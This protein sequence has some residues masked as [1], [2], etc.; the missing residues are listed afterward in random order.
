MGI[1]EEVLEGMLSV[2]EKISNVQFQQK[3]WVENKV[4]QYAFF[5]ETMHQL[6]DDYELADILNNYKLYGISNEQYKIL[7]EFY[8]VLD[9]YS[10]EKMSW[11][12]T[13]DPKQVL[14]DSRWHE[15]QKMAKGVLKAFNFQSNASE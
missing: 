12:Q 6:F 1:E 5:E 15:V 13:T 4:H 9:R 10:D 11:L 2:I 14:A 8:K 7:N 3:A